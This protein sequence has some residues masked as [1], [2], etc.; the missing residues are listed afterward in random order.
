MFPHGHLCKHHLNFANIDSCTVVLFFETAF[1]SYFPCLPWM[2]V[3]WFCHGPMKPYLFNQ[4]V[5]FQYDNDATTMSAPLSMAGVS[6]KDLKD[7][8]DAFDKNVLKS[9]TK[10]KAIN[11][12]SESGNLRCYSIMQKIAKTFIP[13]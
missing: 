1:N 4:C 12:R 2:T 7:D 10:K 6:E 5:L 11:T 8:H 13:Q 3:S 9:F